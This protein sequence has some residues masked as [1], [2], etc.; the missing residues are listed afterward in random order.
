MRRE[1]LEHLLRA[2]S[3]ITE[4]RD[5]LV[6]GSQAILATYDEDQLPHATT[7]SLEADL[8]FFDDPDQSISDM[9]DGILGEDSWFH[10]THGFYGQGVSVSVATLPNGWS[11][12]LVIID[13][14]NTHP[15]RG[16]CLEPH[17]LVVS[18]L[19][20]HREKDLEFAVALLNVGLVDPQTLDRRLSETSSAAPIQVE[21]ARA[22]L[23]RTTQIT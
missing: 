23:S 7:M 19:I 1:D 10:R 6:L 15:G 2:A 21:R 16:L 18:K 11:E 22:W 17:D 5:V 3:K 13:G 4:R 20:A 9:V 12:R 8:A 14:R